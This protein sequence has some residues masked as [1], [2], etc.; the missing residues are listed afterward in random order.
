MKG[1]TRC[2]RALLL[3]A[4]VAV[5]SVV[6]CG[7][8]DGSN[9]NN[10]GGSNTGGG[11]YESVV[12]GGKRWMSKNLNVVTSDSWCYNNNA[13]NCAKYGRLY[14]WSSAKTACPSGWKLPDTADW[15]RLVAEVGGYSTAGKKL[16]SKSG[17][18][19]NGNGTNDYGFLALPGGFRYTGGGFYNAGRIGN[20]WT[21]T[22]YGN[23]AYPRVMFYRNDK[24]DEG[25]GDKGYGFSVRCV[26]DRLH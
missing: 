20:W 17:W 19:N 12:I 1:F 26:E 3:A 21:A 6:L 2:G 16:K 14:T 22:E 8:D 15:N 13:D 24:V 7:C 5:G 25:S 9:P 11:S 23:F 4:A 18:N 10:S